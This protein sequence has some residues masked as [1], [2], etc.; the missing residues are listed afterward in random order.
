MTD[1]LSTCSNLILCF[2]QIP[3]QAGLKARDDMLSVKDAS[4]EALATELKGKDK[5]LQANKV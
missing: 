3:L 2:L 4:I 5:I 1:R